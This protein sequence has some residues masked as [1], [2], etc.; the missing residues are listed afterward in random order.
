MTA[1]GAQY[2]MLACHFDWIGAV[3][4]LLLVTFVLL[5]AYARERYPTIPD[6]IGHYYGDRT[7]TLVALCM[8]AMMLLLS[9]VC[10]CAV[11]QTMTAFL[12]WSFGLGVLVTVSVVLAYTPIGGLR[13]TIYTE[14]LH[15]QWYW[16]RL[17][18]FSSSWCG[19]L[20]GSLRS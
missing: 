2:G 9:G 14:L 13:A 20:A 1:L 18:C 8:A 7:R 3:P 17:C 15:L 4:A 19:I 12:G 5:P 16:T 10:L 6:F 11:T